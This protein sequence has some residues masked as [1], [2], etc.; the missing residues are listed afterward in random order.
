V[1]EQL[2]KLNAL[3]KALNEKGFNATVEDYAI[4][5]G[6]DYHADLLITVATLIRVNNGRTVTSTRYEVQGLTY[7]NTHGLSG[8]EVIATDLKTIQEVVTTVRKA[9]KGYNYEV[10]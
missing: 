6:V 4:T 3:A 9:V 7:D 10:A 1:T 2:N 5:V 8:E